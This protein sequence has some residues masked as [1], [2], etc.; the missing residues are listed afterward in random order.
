MIDLPKVR[1]LSSIFETPMP[2][3]NPIEVKDGDSRPK[4]PISND[5][6]YKPSTNEVQVSKKKKRKINETSEEVKKLVEI[7]EKIMI[8][9]PQ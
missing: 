4:M 5:N 2:N 7:L 1:N 6:S 9:D 8:E 3:Q